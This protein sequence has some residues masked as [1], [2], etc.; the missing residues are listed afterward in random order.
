[1]RTLFTVAAV[2]SLAGS[3]Q[4]QTA[5]T[6][7]ALKPF[8]FLAGSCWEGPFPDGK[9]TD[10]HC[11]QWIQD[12]SYLRDMHQVIGMTPPYYGETTYYWDH[13]AKAVKYIYWAAGGGYS[14]GTA[15]VE[16]DTIT[17]PDQRYVSKDGAM[18][19]RAQSKKI[20]ADSYKQFAEM[21]QKD[22]TWKAFV[23]STYKRVPKK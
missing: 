9:H 1:M 5:K 20:D 21:K 10:Q 19:V 4:A 15:N 14:T 12:G 23:D 11:Y 22:G 17:Y 8:A 2:L 18:L 16:G 13:D 6:P 3:V 7:D